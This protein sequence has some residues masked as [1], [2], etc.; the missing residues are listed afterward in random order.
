MQNATAQAGVQRTDESG[1]PL[2]ISLRASRW[3]WSKARPP[4]GAGQIGAGI[5]PQFNLYEQPDPPN[6]GGLPC[7]I[8]KLR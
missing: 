8:P 2:D 7:D 6:A 4:A 1:S 5:G 3:S